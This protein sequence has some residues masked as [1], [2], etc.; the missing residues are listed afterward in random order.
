MSCCS[1]AGA[2][3]EIEVSRSVALEEIILASRDL[4]DGTRQTDLS[5][6]GM[7]CGACIAAVEKTLSAL[8]GV[9]NARV[10]LSTRRVAVRW[11]TV[12]GTAPDLIGTLE[13]IGYPAHLFSFEADAKDPE[14]SRLLKALAVAGFCAMNIMLLS[15]SVWS[16][17][18]GQTRQAFHLVSAALALPA[19][20]YSGRIFYFSAWSA[21]RHFRTNMDV[22]ISV[23]VTLAFGLSL[24]DTVH[25]ATYAYFDAATS[26]LFFLL[27]GRTL[28]H[29]MREKARSAVAG[30]ARLAPVGA[31][32]VETDGTR[33]YVPTAMIEPGTTLFIAPGDRIAV[34]GVVETGSSDLDCS[35]VSG[36]SAPSPASPGTAVRAGLMNLTGPL[37]MRATARAEDSFLAEMVRMMEAAEGGRARYRRLADR[38]AALYSPVVHTIA[39]LSLAAWLFATGDW[40]RSIAVA[41]SVLIITCPC[42]LGLAVPIVQVVAARRLFERGI[43]VKDGSALERLAEA[44]IVLFDKTGVLTLGKPVLANADEIAPAALGIAAA[45][46]AGSRHPSASAIAAAGAGRL[47]PPFAFEVKE[48]PGLGLEAR[49]EGV[50]YRLGRHDWATDSSVQHEQYPETSVAVL[51]KDREWLA[52]FLI[53]DG[54][55]PGADQAVRDLKSAGLQVGIVSGDRRQLVQALARRFDID[56]VEAE[57]LPAG[58]LA[59]IEQLTS[60][61]GKVLMVGDGLN[62]G[63][64][65]AAA[66]VS[67]APSTAVDIGRNAADFVFLAEGLS[68]VTQALDISRRA[69]RLVRQNFGLSIAYNALAV[70]I[71][72]AGYV[73]PLLAALAMSLSSLLVVANAMRLRPAV[74]TAPAKGPYASGSTHAV[75]GMH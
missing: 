65:L 3:L 62:D 22:P 20:L 24:Y 44:E 54:V 56:Q 51:T 32:I 57:S 18:S 42:A 39:L 64:A 16:G 72:V 25:G 60:C 41:I 63:P 69:G 46:A 30:L 13:K 58:K 43:M 55:R 35:L 29:M 61:G 10:N 14:L 15:V 5:V 66:H 71:A 36:E 45:I 50:V 21:L 1:P 6:P 59:R 53:E 49:A 23:G 48:I 7:H 37:T 68:A 31:T 74:Q 9:A 11:R 67:M 38:A 40:H 28:D 70:P 52:T 8:G 75:A 19:I 4:G 33:R 34:D 47:A 26:L 12:D 2:R 27:A 73:T 17:A